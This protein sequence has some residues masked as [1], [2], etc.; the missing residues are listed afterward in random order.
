MN[1]GNGKMKGKREGCNL[2]ST[3]TGSRHTRSPRCCAG[4]GDGQRWTGGGRVI[5]GGDSVIAGGGSVITGGGSVITGGGSVITGGGGVMT[6]GG[7]GITG[8]WR[9]CDLRRWW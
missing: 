5:T 3:C 9:S 7:G 1:Q 8:G 4:G 6:G 2:Q